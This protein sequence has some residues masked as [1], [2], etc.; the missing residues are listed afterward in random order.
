MRMT[1]GLAGAQRH[2]EHRQHLV[3][4][5]EALGVFGHERHAD[6]LGEPHRHQVARLLDAEAQ[7]ARAA[8]TSPS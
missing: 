3:I 8:T 7:R 2:G 5:A 1:R 4:D 6:I